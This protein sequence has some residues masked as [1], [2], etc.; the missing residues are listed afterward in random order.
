MT[1]VLPFIIP[2]VPA[3][4]KNIFANARGYYCFSICLFVLFLS[5]FSR[6][7]HNKTV[8]RKKKAMKIWLRK[9]INAPLPRTNHFTVRYL[10]ISG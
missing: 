8:V 9:L 1:G 10:G 6:S 2:A 7:V 4:I 5:L 3:S